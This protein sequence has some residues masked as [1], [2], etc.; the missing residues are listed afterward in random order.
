MFH[1]I[2]GGN[3]VRRVAFQ[4]H[5]KE[6][7][8]LCIEAGHEV[9]QRLRSVLLGVR[10]CL[11]LLWVQWKVLKTWPFVFRRRASA[12]ENFLQLLLLVFAHEQRHP[13]DDLCKDTAD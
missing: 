11:E 4:H 13:R 5:F 3:A 7:Q 12:N 2:F 10:V 9:L 8:S 6:I 1:G